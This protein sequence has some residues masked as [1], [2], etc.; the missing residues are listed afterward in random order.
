MYINHN[1]IHSR[2]DIINQIESL[3]DF[4]QR[5]V[6]TLSPANH[7]GVLTHGTILKLLLEPVNDERDPLVHQSIQVRLGTRHF[8]HHANLKNKKNISVSRSQEKNTTSKKKKS[9]TD[10]R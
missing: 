2:H 9:L 10:N 3:H 7:H 1:K 8:Y 6:G 5:I 4:V